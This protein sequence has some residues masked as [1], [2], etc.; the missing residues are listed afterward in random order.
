MI[1]Q[2]YPPCHFIGSKLSMLP[3]I[4]DHLKEELSF[5]TVLDLFGGTGII[6]H[7]LRLN[8]KNVIYNDFLKCLQITATGLLNASRN[9]ILSNKIVE[10]ILK[11]NKG[12]IINEPLFDY[13]KK[14]FFENEV[15]KILQMYNQIK[16]I[17]TIQQDLLFFALFQSMLKKRP[18]HTFHGSFLQM[19]LKERSEKQTWDRNLETTFKESISDINTFLQ[20]LPDELPKVQI[21]GYPASQTHPDLFPNENIDLL[22]LDP[23]FI[24]NKKKRTLRFANYTKNY[25]VLELLVQQDKLS[26]LIDTQTNSLIEE[27]FLPL[28]EMNLWLDQNQKNWIKSFEQIIKNFSDSKIVISYR[29]DS[30]IT[31]EQILDILNSY[32]KSELYQTPHIYEKIGKQSKF[33]DYLFIGT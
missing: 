5:N 14:Y 26:S 1:G 17:N 30:L 25:H 11:D 23:P 8:Q 3:W 2:N 33:N 9:D 15:K 24:S 27:K 20:N 18:F 10:S 16:S 19:R 21:T 13:L 31:K 32:K 6:S 7:E 4:M 12:Y 28:E 22:Y 29:S